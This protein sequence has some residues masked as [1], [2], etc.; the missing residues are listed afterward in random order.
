MEATARKIPI[1]AKTATCEA[2]DLP[3]AGNECTDAR[4]CGIEVHLAQKSGSP[5]VIHQ[6][7]ACSGDDERG[8]GDDDLATC[9]VQRCSC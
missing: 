1:V 5:G 2:A 7:C 8:K 4:G 6:R 9:M 3:E